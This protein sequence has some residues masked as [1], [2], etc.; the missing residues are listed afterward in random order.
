MSMSGRLWG[1][2]KNGEYLPIGEL[3]EVDISDDLSDD[4]E[5]KRFLSS[6]PMEF[7]CEI[8]NSDEIMKCLLG[9]G[10]YNAMK[11]KQDGYL[12][13]ENGWISEI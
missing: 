11:L 6:K 8:E 1:I 4:T 5:Y 10:R 9:Q 13:P 3:K 12:S 2:G 7:R